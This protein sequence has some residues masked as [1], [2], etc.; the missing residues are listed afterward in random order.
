MF[1]V[2]HFGGANAGKWLNY[3]GR[4]ENEEVQLP[5]LAVPHYSILISS[6]QY[7]IWEILN[8]YGISGAKSLDIRVK[9]RID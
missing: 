3:D 2:K 7:P 4:L 5:L 6:F 9:M 1:H 8:E